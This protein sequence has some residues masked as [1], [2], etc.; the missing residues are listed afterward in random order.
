M[1]RKI[2]Q[3]LHLLPRTIQEK[4]RARWI[5]NGND[6]AYLLLQIE[7]WDEFLSKKEGLKIRDLMTF[8]AQNKYL[9]FAYSQSLKD[10]LGRIVANQESVQ[11]R[12]IQYAQKL[13]RIFDQV[14]DVKNE[15]N[16][17]QHMMGYFSKEL[18]CDQRAQLL[19]HLES[20][21][22]GRRSRELVL[23]ELLY[24]A[25]HFQKEYLL[26]QSIFR[27]ID[28]EKAVLSCVADTI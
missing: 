23:E 14:P 2:R 17:F 24:F 16:A 15:I 11:E 7:L 28:L 13:E 12:Y 8:H 22:Q 21:R 18:S 27:L 3:K 20:Y 1:N 26:E 5:Q 9:Y 4:L 6:K 10:E 19:E 25:M